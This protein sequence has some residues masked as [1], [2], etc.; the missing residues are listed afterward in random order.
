[1]KKTLM[2]AA[3]VLGSAAAQAAE[4]TLLRADAAAMRAYLPALNRP[5]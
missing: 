5:R 2:I 3:I 1:M 4:F